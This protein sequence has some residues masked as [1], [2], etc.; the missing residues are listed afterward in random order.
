M[1]Y[2]YMYICIFIP[3][4]RYI[5]YRCIAFCSCYLLNWSIFF[6]LIPIFAGSWLVTC[7]CPLEAALSILTR[8]ISQI[9]WFQCMGN[10]SS[11]P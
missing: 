4:T 7:L 11:A 5:E 3:R 10:S 2:I 9:T 6:L 8:I 1:S